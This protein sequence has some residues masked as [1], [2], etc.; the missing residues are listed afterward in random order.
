MTKKQLDILAAKY[1]RLAYALEHDALRVL[2]SDHPSYADSVR[3][4]S[5][6]LGNLA[7]SIEAEIT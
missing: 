5:R 3:D 4:I 1:H 6:K 7:R 2:R